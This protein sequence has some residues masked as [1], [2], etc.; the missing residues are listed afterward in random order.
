LIETLGT[1]LGNPNNIVRVYAACTLEKIL[2]MHIAQSM[3]ISQEEKRSINNSQF[4]IS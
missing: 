1:F 4:V 2:N 3:L